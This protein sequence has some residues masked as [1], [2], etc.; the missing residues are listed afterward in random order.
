MVQCLVTR[1]KAVVDNPSLPY[2]DS[3]EIPVLN[4]TDAKKCFDIEVLSPMKAIYNGPDGFGFNVGGSIV[5]EMSLTK[6]WNSLTLT[7][8]TGA[9]KPE[10]SVIFIGRSNIKNIDLLNGARFNKDVLS[11][12]KY[13]T[14]LISISNAG[15]NVWLYED[16]PYPIKGLT[17][18]PNLVSFYFHDNGAWHGVVTDLADKNFTN[19]GMFNS[20]VSGAYDDLLDIYAQKGRTDTLIISFGQIQPG[21]SLTLKGVMLNSTDSLWAWVEINFAD[22]SWSI[23]NKSSNAPSFQD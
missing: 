1:L 4:N 12:L 9:E 22:G 19:I 16:R 21:V 17:E 20:A 11:Q 3:L 10:T 15:S 7:T 5:K 13:A 2:F 18:I 23:G 8:K 6:G 14:N